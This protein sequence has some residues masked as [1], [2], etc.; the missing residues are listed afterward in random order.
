LV[1]KFLLI[2]DIGSVEFRKYKLSKKIK[3]IVK[4]NSAVKVT[5]PYNVS[6]SD[7]VNFVSEKREW[8][9]SH[10]QNFKEKQQNNYILNPEVINITK[11]HDL[12]L[13]KNNRQNFY[14]SVKNKK[15]AISYPENIS[16]SDIRL[17][18]V[19]NKGVEIALKKETVD[20]I[21]QRIKYLAEKNLIFFNQLKI[22]SAKS[23]WG[24]CTYQNNINISLHIMR[25][26]NHLIDYVLLHELAH[27]KVKN[28]S[29]NFW[30]FLD[31]LTGNSKKLDK[32]LKQ[33]KI[34]RI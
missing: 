11:T 9:L 5:L 27:V 13:N 17:Q 19:I 28:H 16:V 20:Y 14:I 8:I 25:L 22:N 30:D 12:I 26:P 4:T 21:P 34:P 10:L 32:E 1:Q 18:K 7:A 6:Y 31:S 3:I 33:Y 2:Q 24:S 15:I 23:K 29:K